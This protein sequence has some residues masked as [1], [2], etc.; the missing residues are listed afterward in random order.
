MARVN[1][2]ADV[3]VS[4]C[5]LPRNL[6]LLL[7]M[8]S[9][10]WDPITCLSGIL[11]L[12]ACFVHVT[13]CHHTLYLEVLK[14]HYVR[15]LTC[16]ICSPWILSPKPCIPSHNTEGTGELSC[17]DVKTAPYLNAV[18]AFLRTF[19]FT[20]PRH[21]Y[22]PLPALHNSMHALYCTKERLKSS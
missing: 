18:R 11:P 14:V 17:E 4:R 22:H 16:L 8:N 3:D 10:T 12:F 20:T 2:G 19:A 7:V 9:V 21:Q 13:T 15:K 6:C 5:L 1:L